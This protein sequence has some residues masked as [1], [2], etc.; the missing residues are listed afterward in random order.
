MIRTGKAPPLL[1]KRTARNN[2]VI[3]SI[4]RRVMLSFRNLRQI[5]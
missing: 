2:N 3:F 5:L 4:V 1:W